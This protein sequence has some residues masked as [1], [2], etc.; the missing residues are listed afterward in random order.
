MR[1]PPMVFQAPL[2]P[3]FFDLDFALMK[4]IRIKERVTFA[5]GG[6][7]YNALNH[8]NLDNPLADVLEQASR[9]WL[10][11]PACSGRSCL[12]QPLLR[13]SGRSRA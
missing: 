13:A 12:V 2:D 9:K 10:L 4:D 8:P 7:A 11:P 3:H 5:F 1:R 6:Q